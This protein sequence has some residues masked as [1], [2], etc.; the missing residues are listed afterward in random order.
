MGEYPIVIPTRTFYD[1]SVNYY[2]IDRLGGVLSH[3]TKMLKEDLIRVLG[4][5][6]PVITHMESS[7][8]QN[9]DLGKAHYIVILSDSNFSEEN[10]I[11]GNVVESI[12]IVLY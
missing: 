6:H 4:P 1:G 3:I 12:Y 8:G 9:Q 7:H 11:V 10:I 5:E 2:N